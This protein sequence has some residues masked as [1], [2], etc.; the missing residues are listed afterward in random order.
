MQVV[1]LVILFYY[2]VFP[3]KKMLCKGFKKKKVVFFQETKKIFFI[4]TYLKSIKGL[5]PTKASAV[6]FVNIC[7]PVLI[8]IL[9]HV[10]N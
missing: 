3:L 5:K 10:K 8:I 1:L 6:K 2:R 7:A 9:Y 4:F